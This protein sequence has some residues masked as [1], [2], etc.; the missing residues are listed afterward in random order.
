MNVF[1]IIKTSYHVFCCDPLLYYTTNMLTLKVICCLLVVYSTCSMVGHHCITVHAVVTRTYAIYWWKRR[2]LM[3]ML[4]IWWVH[5]WPQIFIRTEIINLKNVCI[6]TV[7]YPTTCTVLHCGVSTC[8]MGVVVWVEGCGCV[9]G[10]AIMPVTSCII[11]DLYLYNSIIE[12]NNLL[13]LGGQNPRGI[14]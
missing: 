12:Y 1:I 3:W 4:S 2:E 9:G 8:H 6:Y 14:W 10:C 11:Y 7:S 13:C 5:V